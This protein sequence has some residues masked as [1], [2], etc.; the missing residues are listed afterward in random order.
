MTVTS[1]DARNQME[2]K[3]R[4]NAA[5]PLFSGT[6]VSPHLS[7]MCLFKQ[8]ISFNSNQH[9]KF[10]LMST[11]LPLLFKAAFFRS[12]EVNICFHLALLGMTARYGCSKLISQA[13][14]CHLGL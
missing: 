3:F 4:D 11:H 12:L 7:E 2:M 5:R 6:A 13:F 1:Q 10:Y 8:K 14:I 9:Q